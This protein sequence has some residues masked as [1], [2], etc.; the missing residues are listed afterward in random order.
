MMDRRKSP[1]E[2]IESQKLAV[3]L[4]ERGDAKDHALRRSH[5]AEVQKLIAVVTIQARVLQIALTVAEAAID[6]VEGDITSIN[7]DIA[8]ING[9]VVAINSSLGAAQAALDGILTDLAGITSA[10]AVIPS[11]S[12]A[13]AALGAVGVPGIT[14]T[15]AAG[16]A[17]TDAEFNLV[18]DD[19]AALQASQDPLRRAG[20]VTGPKQDPQRWHCLGAIRPC[21]SGLG[22][23]RCR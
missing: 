10:I 11:H 19:L 9:E 13:L 2:Q 7:G 12:A 17:P 15:N 5:L 23:G 16:D 21:R 1:L 20:A 4:G 14:A 6:V 8:A 18:V 22:A 3:L